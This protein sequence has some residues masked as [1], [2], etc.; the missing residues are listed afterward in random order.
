MSKIISTPDE[1][2]KLP[3]NELHIYKDSQNIPC[4]IL[5]NSNIQNLS[6]IEMIHYTI[7]NLSEVFLLKLQNNKIYKCSYKINDIEIKNILLKLLSLKFVNLILFL[8]NNGIYPL[9][10]VLIKHA[11]FD[12]QLQ[13]LT[14]INKIWE[15]LQTLKD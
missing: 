4:F 6:N 15:S 2:G 7:P 12:K 1:I 11:E 8:E 10:K 14:D 9:N 5:K 13:T 3:N